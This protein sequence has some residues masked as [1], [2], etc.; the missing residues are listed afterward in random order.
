IIAGG[1]GSDV[2][3]SSGRSLTIQGLIQAADRVVL[4]GGDGTLIANQTSLTLDNTATVKTT[5]AGGSITIGGTNLVYLDGEVVTTLDTQSITLRSDLGQ[6]DLVRTSGRVSAA[7]QL[8]ISG[9]DLLLDGVITSTYLASGATP[10]VRASATRNADLHGNLTATGDVNLSVGAAVEFYD[11]AWRMGTLTLAAQT[12]NFGY[13]VSALTADQRGATFDADTALT[14]AASDALNVNAAVIM[15]TRNAS[16]V[17][18]LDAAN[19]QLVGTLHAGAK[20]QSNAAVANADGGV[21]T[22]TATDTLKL[23]VTPVN[24]NGIAVARGANVL[25]T[26][27]IT[28]SGGSG[29]GNTIHA[30]VGLWLD[31][32]SRV[33]VQNVAGTASG[34]ITLSASKDVLID[35]YVEAAQNGGTVALSA[36]RQLELNGYVLGYASVTMSGGTSDATGISVL[37]GALVYK[38]SGSYFVDANGRLMDASGWLRNAGGDYVNEAGTVVAVADKVVGGDPVRLTGAI[39]DTGANGTI[40]VSGSGTLQLDGMLG[41]PYKVTGGV[42]ARPASVAIHGSSAGQTHIFADI[43]ALTSIEITGDSLNV[44]A[45]AALKTWGTN[46]NIEIVGTGGVLVWGEST[47]GAGDAATVSSTGWAH[48]RGDQVYIAGNVDAKNN[49]W[50]NAVKDV[51]VYG[52]VSTTLDT[53]SRIDVRAGLASSVSD[54]NARVIPADDT[55]KTVLRA[56]LGAGSIYMLGA[57]KLTTAGTLELLAGEDMVLDASAATASGTKTVSTP[58]ISTESVTIQV[59]NGYN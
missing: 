11:N 35:G 49:I 58:I 25:S 18:D 53:T 33:A 40:T 10:E 5:D 32:N 55:A 59:V 22:V 27:S 23:G 13:P 21:V 56:S 14:L 37:S 12:A 57:G 30:G 38:T 41:Q 47:S 46:G 4:Q 8:D 19:I 20:V 48:L 45:G 9:R 2:V 44:R 29:A 50:L 31:S 7:G 26:G 24:G 42:S 6:L 54:A 36:A 34:S 51:T 52:N 39:V 3:L 28:L 43:N 1:A 16:S 15:T 17:I